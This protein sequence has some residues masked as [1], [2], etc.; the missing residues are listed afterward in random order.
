MKRI[1]TLC[2]VL[3]GAACSSDSGTGSTPDAIDAG[4]KAAVQSVLSQGLANDTTFTTLSIFV[5][6]FIDRATRQGNAPGDSTKLVAVQLDINAMRDTAHVVAQFSG[7]LGWRGYHAS[8][9]T[10][11][12]VFFIL[13]A[14]INP[15]L[16]D[17]LRTS[18]SPDTAGTGTGF[19]FART[20]G[21]ATT[22]WLARGGAFH[23]SAA[24]YGNPQILSNSGLT[25]KVYRG[26]M[27]GDYHVIAKL[28]P[29][30]STTVTNQATFTGGIHA[31]KLGITGSF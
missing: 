26:T 13:G 19:V 9:H 27:N 18:F 21:G 11:D 30:S 4:E 25:L 5:F 17:S 29:D 10:V 7:I 12:S 22:G 8:T 31:L 14:G 15:P 23:A 2:A 20:S 24:S 28:I 6:P 3:A 16:D 1:V